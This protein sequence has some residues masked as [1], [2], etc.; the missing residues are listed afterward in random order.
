MK[1][2]ILGGGGITEIRNSDKKLIASYDE[3]TLTIVI[4]HRGCETRIRIK[5]DG[6]AEVMNMKHYLQQNSKQ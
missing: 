4:I 2:P 5:A 6:S 1:T 3:N